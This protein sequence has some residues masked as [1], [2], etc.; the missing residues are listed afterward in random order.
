LV[1]VL[2]RQFDLFVVNPGMS[3]VE[4]F[5]SSVVAFATEQNEC[6]EGLDQSTGT[7]TSVQF[8]KL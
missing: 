3:F 4:V 6:R 1:V 7:I 8:F 5:N 2:L